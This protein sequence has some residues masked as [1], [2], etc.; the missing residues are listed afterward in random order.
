MPVI[1]SYNQHTDPRN[2]CARTH[3]AMSTDSV[4]TELRAEPMAAV[5][6]KHDAS[7]QQCSCGTHDARTH[8][9]KA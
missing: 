6:T 9:G 5:S 3:P 7:P 4:R 2:H 1:W 8:A